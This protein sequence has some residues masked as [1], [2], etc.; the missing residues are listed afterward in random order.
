MDLKS[1]TDPL[2]RAR[3]EATSGSGRREGKEPHTL[4]FVIGSVVALGLGALGWHFYSR[5][6]A[7]Q[8]MQA[9]GATLSTGG[10][11]L[12]GPAAREVGPELVF[13]VVLRDPPRG[14][15]LELV[16][17]WLN[18]SGEV[19]YENHWETKDIDKAPWPTHCRHHFGPTDVLGHWSVR[20]LS[21]ERVL[22]EERFELR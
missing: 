11:P 15:S 16:C 4:L 21:G 3:R 2:E 12:T 8:S 1:D 10:V 22:G 19:R 20:M 13:E 5:H 18:P 17:H 14:G 7:L 6:R 9:A